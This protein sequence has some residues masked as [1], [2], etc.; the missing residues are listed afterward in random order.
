MNYTHLEDQLLLTTEPSLR[1]N[2]CHVLW[3]KVS[4]KSGVSWSESLSLCLLSTW[5]TNACYHTG[6]R[7]FN[8]VMSAYIRKMPEAET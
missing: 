8:L 4:C 6:I 7:Y 2:L 5:I 1:H 3:D